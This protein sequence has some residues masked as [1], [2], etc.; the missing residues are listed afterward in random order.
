MNDAN[1]RPANKYKWIRTI[2]QPQYLK[3]SQLLH[4]TVPSGDSAHILCRTQFVGMSGYRSEPLRR[5]C[6]L[7][8]WY[9]PLQA[10]CYS[11]TLNLLNDHSHAI[12]STAPLKV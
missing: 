9:H 10:F 1:Q 11:R 6:S 12:N 5:V 2:S 3:L 7:N 4:T 8:L